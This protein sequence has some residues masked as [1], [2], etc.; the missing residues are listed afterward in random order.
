MSTTVESPIVEEASSSSSS[1]SCEEEQPSMEVDQ[2]KAEASSSS[3]EKPKRKKRKR[4][5]EECAEKEAV[6]KKRQRKFQWTEKNKPA[7]EKCQ[8]TRKLKQAVEQA[9]KALGLIMVD[10]VTHGPSEELEKKK[11]EA[12]AL[13]KEASAALD[14]FITQNRKPTPSPAASD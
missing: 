14:V 1:A 10:E 13:L 3:E 9:K 7:F 11:A 8:A 6:E 2:T 5:C 4:L 12:T